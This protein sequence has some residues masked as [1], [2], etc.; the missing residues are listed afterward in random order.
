MMSPTV[1]AKKKLLFILWA[2]RF[3][4]SEIDFGVFFPW[5]ILKKTLSIFHTDSPHVLRRTTCPWHQQTELQY[6]VCQE[7]NLQFR[8]SEYI[9]RTAMNWEGS[10][11]LSKINRIR[12]IREKCYHCLA[13]WLASSVSCISPWRACVF[14]SD[15]CPALWGGVP[16]SCCCSA[17][18]WWL[19]AP[20]RFTDQAHHRQLGLGRVSGCRMRR[21][22]GRLWRGRFG[23]SVLPGARRGPRAAAAG[24]GCASSGFRDNGTMLLGPRCRHP[25]PPSPGARKVKS[26]TDIN[27][28]TSGCQLRT[29]CSRMFFVNWAA[30]K[31]LINHLF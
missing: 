9:C 5:S 27:K 17:L 30:E 28:Q 8:I 4:L 19:T 20:G 29:R 16:G 21:F 26:S 22:R 2:L 6:V 24:P 3:F 13:I 1:S 25:L 7:W 15:S 31:C 12:G 11:V 18:P 23:R 10:R 14:M